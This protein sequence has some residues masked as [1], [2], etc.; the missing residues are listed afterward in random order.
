MPKKPGSPNADNPQTDPF[1]VASA[2]NSLL[3]EK[4][5]V[6]V[7]VGDLVRMVQVVANLGKTRKLAQ[8][9]IEQLQAQ[10]EKVEGNIAHVNPQSM[11][12][13]LDKLR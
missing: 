8:Q 1:M 11:G 4:N 7:V 13:R 5:P 10:V 6:Q 9:R 12:T 3:G 2:L